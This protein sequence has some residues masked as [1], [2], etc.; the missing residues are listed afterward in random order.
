MLQTGYR[1]LLLV[2]LGSGFALVACDNDETTEDDGSGGDPTTTSTTGMSTVSTTTSTT[3]G[4]GG[5]QTVNC[6]GN[7]QNTNIPE[8]ECSLL[9]QNCP[10]GSGCEPINSA[11]TTGC[12]QGGLKEAGMACATTNECVGGTVCAFDKCAPF[13]CR[14][15]HEPCGGGFCNININFGNDAFA[16][17]CSFPAVCEL[18]ADDQCAANEDC[19]PMWDQGIATCVQPSGTPAAEGEDC[20]F[21][22]DCGD[23]QTCIG[24]QGEGKC[25]YACDLAN[26]ANLEP[27]KGGCAD[28]SQTC[29]QVSMNQIPGVGVCQPM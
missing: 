21:I 25:R 6:P 18:F 3:T 14:D 2:G 27:G 4:G 15:N 26:F 28:A 5:G 17:V 11:S 7:L 1:F 20:E 22:N 12:V 24:P 8:G 29:G 10:A 9:A 19:H 23:M 13:C 16:F